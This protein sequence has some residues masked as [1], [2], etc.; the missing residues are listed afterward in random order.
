M[1]S[2]Y[3]KTPGV[4][5]PHACVALL[6]FPE[7]AI[8]NW[9]AA[10]DLREYLQ[11]LCD[12]DGVVVDESGTKRTV[13]YAFYAEELYKWGVERTAA[14][15]AEFKTSAA[16]YT[17]DEAY[18]L[19]RSAPFGK[20]MQA[21]IAWNGTVNAIL[22]EGAFFSLAHILE[23]DADLNCSLHLAQDAFYRQALLTLRCFL[24]DVFVQLFFC[25][26][27]EDFAK[28]KLDDFRTPHFR[29]RKGYLQDLVRLGLLTEAVAKRADSLYGKL[30]S[31]VHGAQ[32]EL[33]YEGISE[34]RGS[35]PSFTEERF[36]RW[37]AL[38]S[39]CVD[40][41]LRA[42]HEHLVWWDKRKPADSDICSTCHRRDLFQY[43]ERH[44]AGRVIVKRT[45]TGCGT[46]LD[47]LSEE[48]PTQGFYEVSIGPRT[49]NDVCEAAE[50][51]V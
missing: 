41:G 38:F 25:N 22:S 24:E 2:Y 33:L 9:D 50:D 42:L 46:N 31:T 8:V 39:D 49:E 36:E 29:G 13:N 16:S 12:R 21:E 27:Q 45:C 43:D 5:I 51:G 17:H 10:N 3:S 32:R 23:A 37:C 26:K 40:V 18:D 4:I 20:A 15:V 7:L 44:V 34:G 14:Y 48:D 6:P 47:F 1:K 30:N 19:L 28:W 11:T 35:G